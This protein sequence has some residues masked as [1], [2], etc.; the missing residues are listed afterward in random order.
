VIV[1]LVRRLA[2][3]VLACT[4]LVVGVVTPTAAAPASPL[5]PADGQFD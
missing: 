1:T 4:A 5:P 3:A 2:V